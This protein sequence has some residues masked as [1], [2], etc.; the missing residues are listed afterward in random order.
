[1]SPKRELQLQKKKKKSPQV[2][3]NQENT[4]AEDFTGYM[5]VTYISDGKVTLKFK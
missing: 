3:L 5:K 4:A 1:M 2:K